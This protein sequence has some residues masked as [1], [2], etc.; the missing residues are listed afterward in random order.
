MIGTHP[1]LALAPLEY[2]Y[3]LDAVMPLLAEEKKLL[4]RCDVPQLMNDVTQRVPILSDSD[5]IH[6]AEMALWVE[7]LRLTWRDELAVISDRLSN[8]SLLIIVASRP[9]ARLLPERQAW[10]GQPLGIQVGGLS[11]LCRELRQMGWVFERQ[12]GIHSLQSIVL[13]QLSGLVSRLGCVAFADRLEFA[14]RLRYRSTDLWAP[15]STVALLV[16]CKEGL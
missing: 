4:I 14:A 12:D 2:R 1:R 10:Q 11:H 9:L 3:A 16:A 13:N 6:D 5:Q 8:K 15:C 7:P